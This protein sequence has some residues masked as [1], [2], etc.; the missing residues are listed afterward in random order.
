MYAIRSYYAIICSPDFEIFV[1]ELADGSKAVGLFNLKNEEAVLS[2]S[3]EQISID[4]EKT[5][6]DIWRQKDIGQYTDS[7]S[8]NVA[9]HGVVLIKIM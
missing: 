6:R 8:A 9:P 1:K 7:F 2:F 5:L 4:G 3:W